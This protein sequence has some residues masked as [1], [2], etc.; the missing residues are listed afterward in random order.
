[1]TKEEI[2]KS[3]DKTVKELFEDSY[4][5]TLTKIMK[6]LG[7][8]YE[9]M[10]DFI[11][12]DI[13]CMS[14]THALNAMSGFELLKF[15]TLVAAKTSCGET[16]NEAERTIDSLIDAYNETK[17]PRINDKVDMLLKLFGVT[18]EDDLDNLLTAITDVKEAIQ[19]AA[20]DIDKASED[21]D[22]AS[23][24]IGCKS[25]SICEKTEN[26]CRCN[27]ISDMKTSGCDEKHR[28]R[29]H[30]RSP[31]SKYQDTLKRRRKYWA[32]RKEEKDEEKKCDDK[33]CGE[34]E[35]YMS[36][37]NSDTMDEPNVKFRRIKFDPKTQS[38]ADVLKELKEQVTTTD[39]EN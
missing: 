4:H 31:Y 7:F 11:G 5:H 19:Q 9:D 18:D 15:M 37:Y 17:S 33:E 35:Y 3:F 32:D 28:C 16:E 24:E 36:Y 21:I 13:V 25:N 30:G 14:P 29:R 39:S 23:D 2:L 26:E 34:V 27:T 10:R 22:K 20:E 8:N 1:M 6:R 38:F 12:K